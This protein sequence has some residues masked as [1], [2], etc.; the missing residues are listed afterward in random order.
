MTHS[1]APSPLSLAKCLSPQAAGAQ[2]PELDIAWLPSAVSPPVPARLLP[3]SPRAGCSY[4]RCPAH[5]TSDL[6]A[7]SS[8]HGAPNVS[9]E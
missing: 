3:D 2:V 1:W 5:G 4:P 6:L 8:S 9:C 7:R